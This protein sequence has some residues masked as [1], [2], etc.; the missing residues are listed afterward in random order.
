MKFVGL[1]IGA[2]STCIEVVKKSGGTGAGGVQY[3]RPD[4]AALIMAG[5]NILYGRWFLEGREFVRTISPHHCMRHQNQEN[6]VMHRKKA[7]RIF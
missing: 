7:E 4:G 5:C 1:P 6:L 3:G 2:S